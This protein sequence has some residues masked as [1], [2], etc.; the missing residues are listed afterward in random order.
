MSTFVR[1]DRLSSAKPPEERLSGRRR[2]GRTSARG[3]GVHP[4]P[5]GLAA[6]AGYKSPFWQM[7]EAPRRSVDAAPYK[8]VVLSLLF[9][10][11]TSLAPIKSTLRSSGPADAGLVG[12]DKRPER[13]NAHLYAPGR[14]APRRTSA[15]TANPPAPAPASQRLES[16]AVPAT[17]DGLRGPAR[18]PQGRASAPSTPRASHRAVLEP[19]IAL[20][21]HACRPIAPLYPGFAR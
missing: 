16:P 20:Q 15:D 18:P 5:E 3:Q 7:P 11:Y 6:T 1:H 12:S 13:P 9:P 14:G 2:R 21:P 10:K 4:P 19:R 17:S 8:L